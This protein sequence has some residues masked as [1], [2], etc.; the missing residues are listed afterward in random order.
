MSAT[1]R[2]TRP[3]SPTRVTRPARRPTGAGVARWR[4]DTPAY[5]RG[6]PASPWRSVG[7]TRPTPSTRGSAW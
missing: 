3:A 2:L 4:R 1:P 5:R 6:R 7:P